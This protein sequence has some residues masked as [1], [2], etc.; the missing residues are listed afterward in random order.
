MRT[1]VL[2]A[3]ILAFVTSDTRAQKLPEKIGYT[4]YIS[5]RNLGHSDINVTYTDK[6]TIVFDSETRIERGER[7]FEMKSRTE[8]D[9]TTFQ[10]KSYEFEGVRS[11][12]KV[13]G[14]VHI[15]GK[16][17]IIV[18]SSRRKTS[19]VANNEPVLVFQDFIV[20][21][22][23]II[24]RSHIS[25][26]GTD[27][28]YDL[29]FPRSSKLSTATIQ[30]TARTSV[31]STI[32]EAICDKLVI[33]ITQSPPFASYYDPRRGLPVYVAFPSAETEIFLDEFYGDEP[34]S[35]WVAKE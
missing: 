3:G 13:Q 34:V 22:E 6:G 30:K 7:L 2:L 29:V 11:N 8:V 5:G 18:D 10:L 35:R 4:I 28:T 24:A 25:G 27:Q 20:E 15:D 9:S 32:H 21:L 33:S 14:E 12:R 26:G 16:K 1:A 31:E 23:I 17:V 19:S